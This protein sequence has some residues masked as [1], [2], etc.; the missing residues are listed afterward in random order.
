MVDL[1]YDENTMQ[2]ISINGPQDK[3]WFFYTKDAFFEKYEDLD[4]RVSVNQDDVDAMYDY[5][6]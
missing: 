5:G 2:L 3:D 4:D 1:K 6:Y